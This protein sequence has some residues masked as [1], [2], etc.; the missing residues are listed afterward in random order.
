MLEVLRAARDG[1]P[2]ALDRARQR[3]IQSARR[4]FRLRLPRR[5]QRS[6]DIDESILTAFSGALASLYFAAGGEASFQLCF[7]RNLEA[8]IEAV[9]ARTATDETETLDQL[10][11]PI[12]DAIGPEASARY[13]M[14]LNQLTPPD[15]AAIVGRIE[16]GFS[17][18]DLADI[19]EQ[20]SPDAAKAAVAE[21][22]LRLTEAMSQEP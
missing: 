19:L 11:S 8:R 6:A 7:R 4:W 21:A 15:Q 2:G 9:K 20:S 10:S 13:E 22:V 3:Y 12:E 14:A 16:F 18:P 17:Y 1:N 5:S